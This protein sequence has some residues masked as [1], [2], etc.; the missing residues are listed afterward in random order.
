M[1][2]LWASLTSRDGRMVAMVVIPA[3]VQNSLHIP[4]GYKGTEHTMQ[5]NAVDFGSKDVLLV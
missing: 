4:P 3:P 5:V 1:K 2:S